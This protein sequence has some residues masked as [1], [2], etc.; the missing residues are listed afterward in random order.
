[1]SRLT[2]IPA[3]IL[4]AVATVTVAPAHAT[5]DRD[6]TRPA[7]M[8]AYDIRPC[9]YEDGSGQRACVWDG[10]HMGNGVG[11]SAVIRHGGTARATVTYVSHRWAHKLA[12]T[13]R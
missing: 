11:S 8:G 5:P 10:R 6:A 7:H 13:G 3:L 9:E 2:I 1:M 4:A 12:S